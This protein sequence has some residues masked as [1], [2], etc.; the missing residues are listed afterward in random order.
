MPDDKQL[1]PLEDAINREANPVELCALLLK[2]VPNC[3]QLLRKSDKTQR[4]IMS[5]LNY[6]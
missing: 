4:D 2:I 5:K 1:A 3:M 6:S